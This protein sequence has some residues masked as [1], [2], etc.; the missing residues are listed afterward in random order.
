MTTT[1]SCKTLRPEILTCIA[2]LRAYAAV[3]VNDPQRCDD[4]VCET[5]EQTFTGA[6]KPPTGINLKILMFTA[7]RRLHYGSPRRSI[8]GAARQ[9][10]RLSEKDDG[11]ESDELLLVFYRLRDDQR[12]VLILEVASGLSDEE[13]AEVCD[14]QI[15]TFRSRLLDARR[16]ISRMLREASREQKMSFG[17]PAKK[18]IYMLSANA[19]CAE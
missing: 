8:E 5:I 7:L 2:H 18:R 9:P 13:A 15:D 4:L 19:I 10:V 16:A 3:L 1:A 6:S 14:C 12:E 17:L 11:V